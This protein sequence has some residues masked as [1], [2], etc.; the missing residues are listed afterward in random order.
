MSTVLTPTEI[1]SMIPQREPFRFIDEV[2]EI[3]DEHVVASYRF[4]TDH[5][6]YAGHFPGRPV[7]PGVI[8]VEAMAQAALVAHGIYLLAKE[9]LREEVERTLSVFTDA[10]IE[11]AAMVP[12]GARVLTTGRKVHYRRKRLRSEVRMHLED[13]TLVCAGRLSGI[14]V[15]R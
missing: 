3:D 13:G 15:P 4:R 9:T 1:L 8:L 5:E 2:L 6:F 12:P 7:T 11:F 10:E 14:G